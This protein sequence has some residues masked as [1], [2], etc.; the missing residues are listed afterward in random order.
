MTDEELR[1]L[2]PF[3]IEDKWKELSRRL[4]SED[5]IES[6]ELSHWNDPNE[7]VYSILNNW[8]IYNGS[9]ATVRCICVALVK[10]PVIHR[11]AAEEI[12][13]VSAVEKILHELGS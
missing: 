13:G 3:L 10:R 8:H 4:E 1:R 6:L 9:S 12:F 11:L 7:C 2:I 5:P